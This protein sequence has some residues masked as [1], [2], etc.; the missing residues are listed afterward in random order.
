MSINKASIMGN[1]T[2]KNEDLELK[3]INTAD[4]RQIS[5]VDFSLASNR[6]YTVNGVRH[7]DA[8]FID[9]SAYGRQ[10]E[11]I[12]EYLKQG[13]GLHVE[14]FLRTKAWEVETV[15]GMRIRRKNELAVTEVNL[16]PGGRGGN[17]N[18][19]VLLGNVTRQPELKS[20]GNSVVA[21]FGIA[22]NRSYTPTGSTTKKTET[23][24]I[25]VNFW[26]R[27]GELIA[28]NIKKGQPL[29][30]VGHLRYNA[31]ENAQGEPRSKL[32]VFGENF[33]YMTPSPNGAA[34]AVSEAIAEAA[35][36]PE[37][38]MPAF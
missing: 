26:G 19:V 3:T 36:I 17:Y 5:V 7:D 2:T 16:L 12:T 35:A 38:E 21:E 22:M 9:A 37:N 11:V 15:E 30:V 24:F 28:Q 6:R 29:F 1:I 27:R 4:G 8:C 14:G 25:D 18:R 23:C 34:P 10:A 32:D 13:S 33:E 31:W 20:V